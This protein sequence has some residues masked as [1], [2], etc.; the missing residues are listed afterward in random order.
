MITVVDVC[1][2]LRVEPTPDLTWPVGA[3]VRERWERIHGSL[4]P[5]ALRT[6]T[7]GGGSHCFAVYPEDWKPEIESVIRQFQTIAT[8]QGELP[9]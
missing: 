8:R 4:P 5:K 1:R 2:S 7:A 3:I 9:L 6:K